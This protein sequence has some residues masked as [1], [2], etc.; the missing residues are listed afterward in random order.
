MHL[1]AGMLVYKDLIPKLAKYLLFTSMSVSW[2]SSDSEFF[3]CASLM[4]PN[5]GDNNLAKSLAILW[6]AD[7]MPEIIGLREMSGLW[8]FERP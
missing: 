7:P 5:T 6:G 2:L 3:M 8:G 4:V 1:S